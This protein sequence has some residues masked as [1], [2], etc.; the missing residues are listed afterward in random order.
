[1]P[2][3]PKFADGW[4]IPEPDELISM[5][6][7]YR[8]P[9]TGVVP[10]QYF[11]V[12]P[13]WN[14]DRWI[15]AIEPRPGNP[16]VVHHMLILVI[17]P[18]EDRFEPLREDDSYIGSYAP[19]IQPELLAPGF[20]RFVRAGS[21][22][23]FNV[24]Y[25]PNG[26]PQHDQSYMG[27]KFADPKSVARE[28]TVSIALNTTFRIPPGASNQEVLSRYVLPRDS[29]LLSLMPHMHYRG[30]DFLFQAEY[31]NGERETLLSV[32]H[33][34]FGWQTVYRLKEPK[35]VPRGTV[36]HCLAH[37][38]NSEANL[39][40]PNSKAAVGWGQQTS[41]EMMMGVIEIAPAAEGL[42]HRTPSWTPLV[43][44]FS[45]TGLAAII[46]T[47]VNVFVISALVVGAIRSS[48]RSR[49]QRGS[50]PTAV[51]SELSRD[52]S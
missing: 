30:K 31:P 21:K 13:G 18:G 51:A 22:F 39:N 17:P 7:P 28:V 4:I 1:L 20:A 41:D 24:H 16:S 25:T 19:G 29:L 14:E 50:I 32:P 27:V 47:T 48:I 8:V 10:Y 12:D 34:D 35:S 36:I 43:S 42:V 52:A 5:P 46:L 44:R 38:D 11:V 9:A 6:E 40:N 3:P 45:A 2:D 49:A 33:Y 15:S 26:S 23:V 37:Y